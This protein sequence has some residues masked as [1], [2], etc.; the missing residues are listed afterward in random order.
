[1]KMRYQAVIFDL[2]GVLCTTDRYHYQAWKKLADRMNIY[3]DE[4]INHRLRGVGRME[5]LDIILERYD[6][7]LTGEE[8]DRLA[9]YKN[10]EYVKLLSDMSE[11]DLAPGAVK[12]LGEL[13]NRGY[14]LAVGSSSRNAGFILGKLGLDGCF[15]AVSDG[16][17]IVRPK[18]DP[19]VF[20]RAA[21]YLKLPAKDCLVVED[22]RAGIDAANK[23][24]F[25][26]AGLGEAAVYEKTTYPLA[27]LA[28]L[29]GIL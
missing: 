2:D 21:E 13:R 1:M 17:N 7:P 18:P 8:K 14:L 3:F 10:R 15:D 6:K 26:S 27:A 5:S 22:A 24:G 12:T 19:E 20:Y 4:K 28:D 23:G 11:R 25:D 16:N 29:C 9:E